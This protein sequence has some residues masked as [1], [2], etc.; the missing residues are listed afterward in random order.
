MYD[1]ASNVICKKKTQSAA[2]K[3]SEL[4]PLFFTLKPYADDTF[5]ESN[6][7]RN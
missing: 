3:V 2:N 1:L 4:G 7:K 5:I 6:H